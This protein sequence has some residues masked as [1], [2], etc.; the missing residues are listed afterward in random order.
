MKK[1]QLSVFILSILSLI[2][3]GGGGGHHSPT[4]TTPDVSGLYSF[5]TGNVNGQC[6]DGSS[7]TN[8]PIELTLAVLQSGDNL[9]LTNQT[10]QLNP[11]DSLGGF[12]IVSSTIPEGNI[13]SNGSFRI[14]SQTTVLIDGISGESIINYFLEGN[15]SNTGWNGDYKYIVHTSIGSC[16]FTT[17]FTGDKLSET[18]K[19]IEPNTLNFS[20]PADMYDSSGLL[21]SSL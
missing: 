3:C 8:P 2:G 20:I 1:V 21:G 11:G 16:T 4:F 14:T 18:A 7:G 17:T 19:V 15:F 12:T 9:T 6:S 10:Y 13:Q 5:K